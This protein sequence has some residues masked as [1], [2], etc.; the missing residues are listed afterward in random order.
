MSTLTPRLAALLRAAAGPARPGELA[1]EDAVL[2]AFRLLIAIR[3]SGLP[4]SPQISR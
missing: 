4:P 1:R 3:P 2:M